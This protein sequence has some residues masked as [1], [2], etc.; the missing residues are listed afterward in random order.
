MSYAIIS[1]GGKQYRVRAGERLLVDRLPTGEGKAF[2]PTVLMIGGDGEPRL[3]PKD[4]SVTARVLGQQRGPKIR[5]GKY[6][7]R[8]GFRRHTGFRAALTQIEIES[9][10]GE[11]SGSAGA[12]SERA[13][14]GKPERTETSALPAGFADMTVA[15]IKD[16]AGGWE[17]AALRGALEHEQ[18]HGQRKGAIT[19]L[20]AALADREGEEDG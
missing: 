11:R 14:K 20:E 3:A 10:G 17:S 4:V 1:L 19:A 9:I 15:E 18:Q 5:I 7:Q 12:T 2:S 13:K 8:T 6:R 16:A